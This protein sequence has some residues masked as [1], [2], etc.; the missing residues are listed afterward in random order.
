MS[1][2]QITITPAGFA[3][4]VNA[5]HDGTAPVRISHVGVT[6]QAFNVDTVGAAVPGELKRI[7]TFGGKAVAVDTLH[8]NIRDDS[9]D[10]YTL[11][12]FGLYLSNGVLFAVYSQGTPIMEKAAA[13]TLLLA[14]DIRFAKIT[15]TSIEVGDVDFV[16]PP[17]TTTQ[18]GV[19]RFA[20]DQEATA[21]SSGTV[22]M[23][24]KGVATYINGRFGE[25]A[26]SDFIKGLMTK[27]TAALLRAALGLKSAALKDEG[28]NNGLDADL[29]DGQHGGYYLEWKNLTGT[30]TQFTPA[31]HDHKISEVLEL[32]DALDKKFDKAGGTVAGSVTVNG[33]VATK[34]TVAG[35]TA[36]D[37]SVAS[38]RVGND[39]EL[40][41]TNADNTMALIGIKSANRGRLL[42]GNLGAYGIGI[43]P[44]GGIELEISMG[45]YLIY[46]VFNGGSGALCYI[47]NNS[48]HVAYYK[49]AGTNSWY[50]R[51]SSTGHPDGTGEVQ[52]MSLSDGGALWTLAGYDWGSSRRLKIIEDA[53]IPY[54]L[55]DLDRIPTV[56]GR[57]RPE[58]NDD[59]IRRIFYEA[60]GLAEVIPEGVN[61]EGAEFD[62]EK[63]PAVRLDQMSPLNTHFLK[64]LARRERDS[65]RHALILIRKLSERIRALEGS[66]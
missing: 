21:G 22:G 18:V 43:R 36:G 14:T 44:T 4:I 19:A 15:A 7:S 13:A 55:D 32:Q 66:A 61:P 58:Y 11:R 64:L 47:F 53:G 29:L 57:Y 48:D 2:P 63:V 10:T 31:P 52:Q 23:T 38:F 30:P 28:T 5:E 42:F 20:T 56:I 17:A 46:N 25:G 62:G 45:N 65:H 1:L 49:R 51:K 27:A 34:G 37:G 8:L 50:W 59:G 33:N 16:N 26:P 60:E 6:P 24:P 12:G 35:N 9:T 40:W 54:T 39:V 41:D 3:A